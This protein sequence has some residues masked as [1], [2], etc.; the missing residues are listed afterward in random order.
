MHMHG[1][2]AWLDGECAGECLIGVLKDRCHLIR[3]IMER[4]CSLLPELLYIACCSQAWE[5]GATPALPGE[6]AGSLVQSPN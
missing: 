6:L 4:G 1:K 3:V 2:S 5:A